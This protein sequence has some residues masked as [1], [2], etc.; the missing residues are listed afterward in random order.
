MLNVEYGERF[1]K[2]LKKLR[3]NKIYE[4]VKD[5]CFAQMPSCEDLRFIPNLKKME[6][7][8]NYYRIRVGDYRI[9]LKVEDQ[10]VLLMRVLHRKEIYKYFPR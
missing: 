10:K 7:Y 3:K 1:L 9:G 4:D 2:D 5:L 6:G 8:R